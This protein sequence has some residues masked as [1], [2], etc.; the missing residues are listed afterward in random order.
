MTNPHRLHA[1]AAAHSLDAALR[2]LHHQADAEA[3]AI[4]EEQAA[5]REPLRSA[6]WGRRTA[7]GGHGDPTGD[8][9]L[10]AR[11]GGRPNRYANLVHDVDER[12]TAVARHLPATV[13]GRPLTRLLS[14]I[15][16][17]SPGTAAITTTLLVK[18]DERVRRE[19][20]I[21]PDRKPLT[22]VECPA[23]RHRLVYV[24]TAGP[25][26][27]WTVVCAK[28]CHC[29][30][31][32]CRCGQKDAVEGPVHIWPRDQVLTGSAIS[33]S[34]AGWSELQRRNDTPLRDAARW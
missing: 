23:C 29:T 16:G 32:G 3:R 12:L 30:G 21:G 19:L 9:V 13:I 7:L 27:V 5:A 2:Q 22:G 33:A 10:T 8:A 15:P 24:Q 18:L 11:T 28:P 14:A 20:R 34:S 1:T 6:S 26:D 4:R 17:M 25:E 31:V